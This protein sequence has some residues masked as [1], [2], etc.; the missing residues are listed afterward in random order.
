MTKYNGY[1]NDLS[2]LPFAFVFDGKAY[3]GFPTDTF[4]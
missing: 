3:T 2:T 1:F 4:R